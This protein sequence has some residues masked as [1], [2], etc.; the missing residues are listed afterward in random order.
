MDG[1]P[2]ERVEN[3][4]GLNGNGTEIKRERNRIARSVVRTVNGNFFM[5]PTVLHVL[6]TGVKYYISATTSPEY[7][8]YFNTCSGRYL[9]NN[10]LN[11]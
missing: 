3:E 10:K 9:D 4:R 6:Y 11:N 1:L 5:T 8:L 7:A 2:V